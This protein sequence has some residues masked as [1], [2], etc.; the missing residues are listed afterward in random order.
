MCEVYLAACETVKL[1]L[2]NSFHGAESFL[3]SE[4]STSWSRNSPPFIEPACSLLYSQESTIFMRFCVT[5]RNTL[6]LTVRSC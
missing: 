6:F 3:R 5:C 2:H 4:Q 1:Y